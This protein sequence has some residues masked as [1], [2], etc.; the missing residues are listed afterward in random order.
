MV[1]CPELEN[2]ER[3]VQCLRIIHNQKMDQTTEADYR[4]QHNLV[5]LPVNRATRAK[6]GNTIAANKGLPGYWH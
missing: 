2:E 5:G 3:D 4:K 6:A 1:D